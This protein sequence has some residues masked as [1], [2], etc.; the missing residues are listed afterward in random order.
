M[1]STRYIYVYFISISLPPGL[2]S[3]SVRIWPWA[4]WPGS[5]GSS[6]RKQALGRRRFLNTKSLENK[7]FRKS[8]ISTSGANVKSWGTIKN[9]TK[10]EST[11]YSITL[12]TTSPA[13]VFET[14]LLSLHPRKLVPDGIRTGYILSIVFAS[15]AI[16]IPVPKCYIF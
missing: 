15:T 16:C 4:S 10:R 5:P 14:C 12:S 6:S 9:N 1:Y 13:L 11:S 2:S 8:F 7:E 3:S